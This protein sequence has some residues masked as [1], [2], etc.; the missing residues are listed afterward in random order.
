VRLSDIG[1]V[2]VDGAGNAYIASSAWNAIF[3]VDAA[4]GQLTW[5]AGDGAGADTYPG[6][7]KPATSAAL[8]GPSGLALDGAGS[9][10]IADGVVVRKVSNGVITTFAGNGLVG[11]S[12][13]NGPAT[14]AE[15]NQASAVAADAFG[16]VYI[17]NWGANVI[18]KVSNGVITTI[19]GNGTAGYSGDNGPAT[20]ATLNE[21]LGVAVDAS[22]N[23]YIADTGNRVIREVSNGVITTIAGNGTPGYSGDYG[24]ATNAE[25]DWPDAVA[26]DASGNV[27][28]SD[29]CFVIRKVSKGVITTFAG[30]GFQGYAG[31]NGPAT[32]AEMSW[33][34]G[35]AVDASGN[36]YIADEWNNAARKVSNGVI[37]TIAGGGSGN[38]GD[39][40]PATKAQLRDPWCLAVDTAG[41]VY[42]ADAADN[43]IR[44]VSN[45]VISTVVGNGTAGYVGDNGPAAS[46]ELNLPDGVA[47]DASGD[48]YIADQSNNVIRKV[49]NGV[50]TTIAGNGTA[51]YSGDNGPA[52]SAAL[53]HPMGLA[54]DA[55]GNLYIADR[56]NNV[57]RRVSNGVITT[58]AGNGTAGY[59]GDNGPATSAALNE[60]TTVAVDAPGNVYIAD[61]WNN[62]IRKV[63]NGVICTFAGKGTPDYN[64]NGPVS[65]AWLATPFGVA[66]DASGALYIADTWN[67][68]IR[69]VSDGV[70]TTIAGTPEVRGY[71]GDG[72]PATSAEF[73]S[74]HGL[75]VDP[76]GDVYVADTNN[77]VIRVLVPDLRHQH[78]RPS[79]TK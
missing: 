49:S 35:V 12:G 60:P 59:S 46:A 55:A 29:Y 58:I 4:T 26:V 13:D 64:G 9:L 67:Y 71:S 51:A 14:S 54:F 30:N 42:I 37:T 18:R 48:L 5:I 21:P 72:I 8:W 47:V 19:A 61:Y 1:A 63:S 40:G 11:Y 57:I 50:I 3:R 70:I 36:V 56:G 2:A 17:A 15:L 74:P 66:V 27:Y 28:I 76:A 75:A 25:L 79:A 68:V 44:K 41:Q 6:D 62:V 45:G 20:S 53:L 52:T 33:P 65:S 22:G 73:F 31:D 43:V 23:V 24:P 32:S 16:N 10:Y 7:S 77:Q 78:R 39:N 69:K 34:I 38:Y